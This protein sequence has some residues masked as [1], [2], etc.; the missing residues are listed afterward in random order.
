MAADLPENYEGQPAFRFIEMVP[1]DWEETRVLN[2]KI[3]H[4]ITTVRKDRNSDDWYLG[5]I[6]NEMARDLNIKLDF[7]SRTKKYNA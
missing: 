7:L 3:G 2:G 6:T 1:T 5:S 4:Y